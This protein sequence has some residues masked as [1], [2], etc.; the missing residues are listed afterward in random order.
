[1]L[2][3]MKNKSMYAHIAVDAFLGNQQCHCQLSFHRCARA[4][5]QSII[6]SPRG[7]RFFVILPL[8]VTQVGRQPTDRNQPFSARQTPSAYRY[9]PYAS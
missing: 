2:I 1:M 3:T 5:A 8:R 7:G 4:G 9:P 6:E